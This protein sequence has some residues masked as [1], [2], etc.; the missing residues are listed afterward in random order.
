MALNGIRSYGNFFSYWMATSLFELEEI[1]R[2]LDVSPD[3]AARVVSDAH[4][5]GWIAYVGTPP[6]ESGGV[7]PLAGHWQLTEAGRAEL[8]G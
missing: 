4:V 6:Y 7:G 2:K 1:A 3:E 8:H 5:S